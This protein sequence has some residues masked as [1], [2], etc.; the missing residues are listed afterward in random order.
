MRAA[1]P[2]HRL[3]LALCLLLPAAAPARAQ[4]DTDRPDLAESPGAV[5]PHSL[6]LEAGWTRQHLGGSAVGGLALDTVGELLLRYGFLPGWEARVEW[7]T[8]HR[9]TDPGPR[10]YDLGFERRA[11][12]GFGGLGMGVKRELPSPHPRVEA[13]VIATA[14][15]PVGEPEFGG[16]DGGASLVFAAS[17]ETAAAD[18]CANVGA[19]VAGGM[20]TAIA[21]VAAGRD[22][23]SRLGAFAE[24]AWMDEGGASASFAGMGLT[25]RASP[26][27]Q[28]DGRGGVTF[29]GGESETLFGFGMARK[30]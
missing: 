3:L 12:S 28:F 6:Q 26:A 9:R 10:P 11:S 21:T 24:V 30:W 15:L 2:L 13:G 17:L 20:G 22:L 8:W 16:G 7:P 18:L 29:A 1:V 27:L 19:G 14:L 25:W 5:A 23:A 4:L